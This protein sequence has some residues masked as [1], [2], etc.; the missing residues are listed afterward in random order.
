M[1]EQL[2]VGVLVT[3][4]T[5]PSRLTATLRGISAHLFKLLVIDNTDDPAHAATLRRTCR[6]ENVEYTWSGAN[7]GIAAAQ[8]VGVTAALGAGADYILFLDDDSELEGSK[9][10][11]LRSELEAQHQKDVDTIGI[12]PRIVESRTGQDLAYTWRGNRIRQTNLADDVVPA[13]FLLGSGAFIFAWAFEKVGLFREDYFID[14]V[15]KEWGLRAGSLGFRLVVTPH[16][17]MLHELGDAPALSREGRKRLY[18]HDSNVRHY[19]L[20]RNALL[21]MRDVRLPPSKYPD[22]MRLL[23]DSVVRK[24]I[25][26]ERSTMTRK[27]VL[28]GLRDGVLNRRGP[29]SG[30]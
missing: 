18:R 12:G 3:Y 9:V 29:W 30:A 15:D 19:Y 4:F 14:H 25:G 24:V 1:A 28:A 17:L 23:L 11:A 22:Q 20:T 27:A 16:V 8:N 2:T 13:A 5:E 26:S 10:D 21:T 6:D 7:V